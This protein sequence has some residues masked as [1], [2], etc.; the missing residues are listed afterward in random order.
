MLALL[1][2][3]SNCLL[4]SFRYLILYYLEIYMFVNNL[5]SYTLIYYDIYMARVWMCVLHLHFDFI[6]YSLTV[7]Y[8]QLWPG[9]STKMALLVDYQPYIHFNL[10]FIVFTQILKFPFCMCLLHFP[11]PT[12]SSLWIVAML[13]QWFR[14][15][16]IKG[17]GS[18]SMFHCWY[19][20]CEHLLVKTLT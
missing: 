2:L 6:F 11:F 20:V 10:V 7:P 5:A 9:R 1:R 4:A 8:I 12:C 13:G 19:L 3:P 15:L 16:L 14:E 17:I 18:R